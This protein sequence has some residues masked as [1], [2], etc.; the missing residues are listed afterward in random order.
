MPATL[1]LTILFF[2]L[3]K[4]V[5]AF[6]FWTY[7]WQ[8]K[9]YHIGRFLA[10]FDTYNGKKLI[11]NFLSCLKCVI[12]LVLLLMFGSDKL[13]L[14][15]PFGSYLLKYGNYLIVSV[16]LLFLVY[17]FEGL[18]VIRGALRKK[19][20]GPRMTAKISF[21]LPV[22]FIP[23]GVITVVFAGLFID[24]YLNPSKWISFDLII[25]ALAVLVFDIL[26]PLIVSSFILLLQPITA[27]FKRRMIEKAKKKRKNLENLLV[28]GITGSYG[29]SSVKE[30]LKFLLEK[31]FRVV[32]TEK[33]ENSEMGISRCILNNVTEEHEI[34]ICEMGAYNRGGIKLLCDIARP[35]IGILTGINSQ[36]LAT[37]GSQKN[38]IKGK[39][40]LTDSL[41]LEGL[42]VLNWNSELI[43]DNFKSSVGNIR[44]SVEGKGDVWAE[45]VKGGKEGISFRVVFK[46][47]EKFSLDVNVNGVHNVSNILAAIAVAKKLGMENENI[48]KRLKEMD[49]SVGGMRFRK[50]N[51]FDVIDATYSSNPDGI[52]SH[53]DY[54]KNWKG[55]KVIVMPC[56]IELGSEGKKVHAEIGK[57]IGEVCDMAVITSRDYFKELRKGSEMK[58]IVFA[59][60]G[61]KIF[62]K[63]YGFCKEGDVVL[64]ESRVPLRLID[65]LLK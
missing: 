51:G 58:N 48:V 29:K 55:K 37:F 13:V 2:W 56:L 47:G 50:V 53:L 25:F 24:D 39:F 19:I 57:K 11:N 10:H 23:L 61:E 45:D 63:L 36:H 42:A 4:E 3:L 14:C 49:S 60:D 21:L 18:G 6:L 15:E 33:N 7:L 46:T 59:E 20:R 35:R 43:K 9:D 34:F 52:I 54:L 65:K 22:I 62:K 26:S 27:F 8:L 12:F 16:P 38:I 1:G 32:S 64:L 5:R 17:I 28:V 40:E 44:Y 31:E 41:P 30:F